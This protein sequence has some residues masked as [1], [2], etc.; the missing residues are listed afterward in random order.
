MF[1]LDSGLFVVCV[2]FRSPRDRGDRLCFAV[3]PG[4]QATTGKKW[5]AAD[6]RTQLDRGQM[7]VYYLPVVWRK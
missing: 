6:T 7:Q 3:C 2:S 5:F 4:G 1:I